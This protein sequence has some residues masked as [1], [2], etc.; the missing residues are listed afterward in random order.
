MP[1][2]DT[3]VRNAKPGLN[4]T[5]IFDGGGMYLEVTTKGGKLW[6]LKYR[7]GGKGKLLA[8]GTYPDVSLASAR[9]KRD[10]ARKLLADGTDKHF[11]GDRAR[12]V[13]QGIGV[14]G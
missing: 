11:R 9:Q 10:D 4:I 3:A 13:C 12:V 14:D 8:L 7:F 6:R 1:L 5:R 2:T